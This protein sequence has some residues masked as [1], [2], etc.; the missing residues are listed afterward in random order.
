LRRLSLLTAAL[1]Q[2][3]FISQAQPLRSTATGGQVTLAQGNQTNRSASQGAAGLMKLEANPDSFENSESFKK[4]ASGEDANPISE[5]VLL[6]RALKDLKSEHINE[7]INNLRQ[8]KDAF[9]DN[10]DYQLLYRTALRTKNSTDRDS[11][12]WYAYQRSLEKKD[13]EKETESTFKKVLSVPATPRVNELKRATWLI[14]TSGKHKSSND[15]KPQD[16]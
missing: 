11:Q 2:P 10:D 13:E 9:P 5:E 1:A 4:P 8:L 16:K 3:A 14:L 15:S 6:S 7:A 12:K